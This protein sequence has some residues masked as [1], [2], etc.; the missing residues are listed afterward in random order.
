MMIKCRE[1]ECLQGML[2]AERE[3][4]D[5]ARAD[6]KFAADSNLNLQPLETR[7]SCVTHT[8]RP[9]LFVPQT[10]PGLQSVTV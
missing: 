4:R 7:T 8:A 3:Y 1:A 10:M 6:Y 9:A 2:D 5:Q